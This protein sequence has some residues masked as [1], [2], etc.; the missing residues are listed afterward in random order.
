MD[1]SGSQAR[2]SFF[3]LAAPLGAYPSWLEALASPA[4]VAGL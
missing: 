1:L 3:D 4:K 2:L